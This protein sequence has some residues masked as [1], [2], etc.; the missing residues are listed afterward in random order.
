MAADVDGSVSASDDGGR[1][2]GDQRSPDD[3]DARALLDGLCEREARCCEARVRGDLHEWGIEWGTE[4][5]SG[6][7]NENGRWS[8]HSIR[9]RRSRFFRAGHGTRTRDF[10]LGN[11]A[12]YQLS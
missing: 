7:P 6:G 10:N 11:V 1:D 5:G 8:A 12:L 2:Q 3:G 9:P 4:V